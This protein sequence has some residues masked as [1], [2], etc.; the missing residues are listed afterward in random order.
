MSWS[1]CTWQALLQDWDH[2]AIEGP[3]RHA[4]PIAGDFSQDRENFLFRAADPL[5][6]DSTRIAVLVAR[7]VLFSEQRR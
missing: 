4:D 7:H 2:I 5:A 1:S 3:T 6:R